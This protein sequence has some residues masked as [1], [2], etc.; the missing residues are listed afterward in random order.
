MKYWTR[1]NYL[2]QSAVV[3]FECHPPHIWVHKMGGG[4]VILPYKFYF[5]RLRFLGPLRLEVTMYGIECLSDSSVTPLP[6]LALVL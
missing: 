2:L 1:P 6:H 4:G 3:W 5:G